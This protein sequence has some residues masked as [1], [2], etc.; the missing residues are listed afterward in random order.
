MHRKQETGPEESSSSLDVLVK[1]PDS[2]QKNT[3]LLIQVTVILQSAAVLK[4]CMTEINIV[5]AV[6]KINK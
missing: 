2:L 5:M 1:S 6:N 3:F 4:T